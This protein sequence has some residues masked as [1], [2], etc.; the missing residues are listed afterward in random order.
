M[1]IGVLPSEARLAPPRAVEVDIP[2]GADAIPADAKE[3][4]AEWR[5]LV[6]VAISSGEALRAAE[7]DERTEVLRRWDSVHAASDYTGGALAVPDDP[8]WWVQ[9]EIV[10]PDGGPFEWTI[11]VSPREEGPYVE[12]AWGEDD[13]EG[14]GTIAIDLDAA[15]A[16]FS[17]APEVPPGTVEADYADDEAARTVSATWTPLGVPVSFE[18]VGDNVLAFTGT[19]AGITED[20]LAWPGG[21]TVFHTPDGGWSE[22]VVIDGDG[23]EIGFTSCWDGAGQVQWQAG[24]PGVATEGGAAAC[25]VESPF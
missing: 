3:A 11:A 14:A 22:G 5:G 17:L 6:Q 16:T 21:V 20:G 4:A 23:D 13:G 10:Q 8:L 18:V 7:P 15:A 19:F 12:V 1:F 24:D 9:G 25:T 2:A